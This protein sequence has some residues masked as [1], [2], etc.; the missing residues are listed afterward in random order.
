MSSSDWLVWQLIDSAFPAG[1]FAHSSG[2]EAAWQSDRV[3]NEED[4]L[5]F[6]RTSLEQAL[7]GQLPFVI[8]ARNDPD[9]FYELD[10]LCN[11]FLSN[12][13]ANRASR[14]QGATLLATCETVFQ[15]SKLTQLRT[16]VIENG[17]S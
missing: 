16:N 12:H 14:R 4:L 2:L 13:V 15:D 7:N 1:S 6:T 11:A 8:S 10:S 17:L 9:L 5:V 3:E